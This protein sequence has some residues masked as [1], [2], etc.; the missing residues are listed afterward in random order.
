MKP[1]KIIIFVLAF[2]VEAFAVGKT[3]KISDRATPEIY[4]LA[5][6]APAPTVPAQL[7]TKINLA[8]E[9]VDWQPVDETK[10][11]LKL[12]ETGEGFH[13]DEIEAKSG[14]KWLGLFHKNGEYFISPTK[15]KVIPAHDEISDGKD[16]KIKTGKTVMTDTKANAVFLLKNSKIRQSGKVRTVFNADDYT[17]SFE[18]TNDSRKEFEF[19]GDKYVLKVENRRTDSKFLTAGSRLILSR[20]GSEQILYYLKDGCNDCSWR[21]YWAGD[22]DADGKLDFYIDLNDHYDV[23]DKQLFLSAPAD[24]EKLVKHVA[25]FTTYGC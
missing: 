25:S 2:L 9:N 5:Q 24:K 11:K 10:F 3:V 21:L 14:E 4:P 7:P 18:L 15:I 19:N 13:G 6:I 1:A 16:Q 20:N 12:L 23:T 17:Q 8:D 22:L